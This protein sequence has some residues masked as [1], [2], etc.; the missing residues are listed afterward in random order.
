[1]GSG[2]TRPKGDRELEDGGETEPK[3]LERLALRRTQ[4]KGGK[5]PRD[6]GLK[7]EGRPGDCVSSSRVLALWSANGS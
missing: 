3:G 7:Y 5:G 2:E 6:E 4:T 1:M